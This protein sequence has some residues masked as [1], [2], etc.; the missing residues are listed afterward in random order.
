MHL[1]PFSH[2]PLITFNTVWKNV[3]FI[4]NITLFEHLSFKKFH[5]FIIPCTLYPLVS[6]K[7]RL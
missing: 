7:N 1:V 2:G 4:T 5:C 6:E 3:I